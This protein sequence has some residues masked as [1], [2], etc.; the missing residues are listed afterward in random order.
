VE[1]GANDVTRL[2]QA[3]HAGDED[4]YRE[5][6]AILY[7]ELRRQ[8]IRCMRG[9]RPGVT[10]QPTALVHEAFMRLAG[11]QRVDWQNRKHFLAI[12]ARTMRRVLVDVVR[13][14]VTAK[15]GARIKLAPLDPGIPAQSTPP[16]DLLALDEALKALATQD[17]RMAEVIELRFFVGLTVEETADFLKV[18]PDTVWKDWRFA[19]AWLRSELYPPSRS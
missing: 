17:A 10:L 5:V 3:W 7:S 2:L 8:A 16:L 18:A 9:E 15:R 1:P 6:S 14:K 11:A 19:K 12:A 13:A 4:A